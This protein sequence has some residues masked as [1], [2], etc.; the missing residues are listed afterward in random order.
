MPTNALAL[1]DSSDAYKQVTNFLDLYARDSQSLING[2]PS[3]DIDAAAQQITRSHISWTSDSSGVANISYYFLTAPTQ[4]FN[5][6]DLG[7]FTALNTQQKAQTL[8]SLQS[9]E[10]VANVH[11]TQASSARTADITYG[12]YSKNDGTGAFAATSTYS[13]GDIAKSEIW[14]RDYSANV[15][16]DTGN[17]GRQTITHE[18]GHALGLSHPGDYNAGQGV[19]TYNDASYAQDTRGYSLMSYWEETY[20]SQDFK[21]AFA[22]APLVDDIAAVQLL[23]G[24]NTSTRAGDT[25]YGFNSNTE[26]D[27]YTATSANSKLVFAVWDGGGNDTLDF[28]G[29]S[30]AQKIDLHQGGFSD[31]GGL[32]GN[33]S[34]AKGANIENAIGGSGNDL[35][36]GNDLANLLRG[37]AGNDIIYGGLGADQL[38]GGSGRDTF[39]YGSINDS[40]AS[41]ADRILDFTSGQDKIDLTGIDAFVNGGLQLSYVDAFSGTAGQ[42]ILAYDAASNAGKLS[43]DF[44][45][46]SQADFAINLIGQATQADIIA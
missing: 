10:D 27:F 7:R 18:T 36:I 14:I 15:S 41:A 20:T 25:V 22:S 21:G 45:G 19:P 28:S 46:N 44:S 5:S 32:I 13:N 43:I 1:K 16:P 35:I 40:K 37:G 33:V 38:S 34:I 31:V 23:Y 42:A 29:F 2:K 11:F 26:R 39:V 17:Y 24:A 9:W 6:E 8:L 30:Q 3:Y 12:V 4:L